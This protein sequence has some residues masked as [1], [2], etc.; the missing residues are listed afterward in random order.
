MKQENALNPA[1][2]HTVLARSLI[3]QL[4][5]SDRP[6]SRFR[7]NEKRQMSVK[8]R[9]SFNSHNDLK[10]LSAFQKEIQVRCGVLFSFF[11]TATD[12]FPTVLTSAAS[13]E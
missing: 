8:L 7:A 5:Y 11:L 2:T 3:E 1:N 4:Y 13:N 10:V 9:Q 6:V 12:E